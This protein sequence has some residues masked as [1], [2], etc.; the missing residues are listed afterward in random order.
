MP[1]LRHYKETSSS[2]EYRSS[3]QRNTIRFREDFLLSLANDSGACF[4]VEGNASVPG[5]PT[6]EL[7][8]NTMFVLADTH[9]INSNLINCGALRIYAFRRS[10]RRCPIRIPASALGMST[11]TGAAGVAPGMILTGLFT[12][13]DAGTPSQ[14]RTQTAFIWQDTVSKIWNR[15]NLRLGRG[16]EASRSGH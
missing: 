3:H 1:F 6:N 12:I 4:Q 14:W 7:A 15:H 9:V 5:W 2:V 10:F 11:P 16:G 13:G 8:Q